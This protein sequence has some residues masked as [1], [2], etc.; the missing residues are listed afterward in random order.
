MQINI[1]N[2]TMKQYKVKEFKEF[3]EESSFDKDSSSE[4][5]LNEEIRD[6]QKDGFSVE[7]ISS[8]MSCSNDT[9]YRSIIL[10]MS[11]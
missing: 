6:C 8:C 9:L 7:S 3:L 11:K 10:L 5:W 1:K 2:T 4:E